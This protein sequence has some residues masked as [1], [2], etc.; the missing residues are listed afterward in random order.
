MFFSAGIRRI[1]DSIRTRG[2]VAQSKLTMRTLKAL[3]AWLVEQPDS[4]L[5]TNP[6][7]DVATSVKDRPAMLA[8]AV[9]AAD[10]FGSAQAEEELSVDDLQLF[11]KVARCRLLRASPYSS[12]S[13]PFKGA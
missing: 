12:L 5:K 13:V 2:K 9:A 7:K 6:A 4:G 1:C 3:F 10:A 11:D 8:D